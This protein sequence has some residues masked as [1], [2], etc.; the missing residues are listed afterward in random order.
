MGRL[1]LGHGMGGLVNYPS[2][3]KVMLS[4]VYRSVLYL[5]SLYG[6]VTC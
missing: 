4:P 6:A 5:T 3:L 2:I 1:A